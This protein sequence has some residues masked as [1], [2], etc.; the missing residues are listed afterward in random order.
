[1]SL[2]IPCASGVSPFLSSACAG[3]ADSVGSTPSPACGDDVE[4]LGTLGDL[5]DP[6]GEF[7]DNKCRAS[8][9]GDAL[10]A[11]DKLIDRGAKAF[12]FLLYFVDA[13]RQA[14]NACAKFNFDVFTKGHRSKFPSKT[15]AFTYLFGIF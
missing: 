2:T 11:L 8:G 3:R 14:R 6:I 15:P 9:F 1:L 4:L 13:S 12:D 10:T 5:L 7:L